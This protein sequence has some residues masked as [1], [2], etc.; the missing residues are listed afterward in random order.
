MPRDD[1]NG[2]SEHDER[3]LMPKWYQHEKHLA[4]M[5]PYVSLVDDRTVR[6][7]VNELFQCIRITGV[8]SYTT[9]DAYLDRV[10]ALF[11]R[12]VAQL[13][14]EFSFYLHKVSKGIKVDLEPIDGDSFAALVDAQ[15]RAK[16]ETSGL[17]DKTLT[18]TVIH[19]PP[20]KS[21]LSFM[22]SPS[23]ARLKNETSK[24]LRRLNEAVGI[25]TSGLANLKPSVLSAETGE[26]VGFLGALNTGQERP[27]YHTSQFGFLASST[28][29]TRVTFHGDYFE[30][31]E[32]VAG[33]RYGK[34]YS[35]KDYSEQTSCT[36][37]DTLNLPVDMIVTHS[38][39]PVNTNMT[40][41]RIKRQVRQMQAAD[42][43]AVSLR[44]NLSF[45]ADDLEAKRASMGDHHMV[46]TVFAETLDALETL[47]AE[48]VNAAASEGVTMVSDRFGANTHYLSQHPGNQPKRLR[49][50]TITNRNFADFAA[51]HRTQL[52]KQ[53]DE[54]PWGK[55]ISLFPTP[56]RSA[57]RFSFHEAGSPDKEPTS[58]HTL[59]MGRPGSGKSVLAAFLMTQAK[60]AGARVFIFDYRQGMEMAVRANGGRYTTIQGG[61]PTGL[62]PLWTEIDSRG[63]AWLADWFG[64]LLH[65]EDKPLTPAQTN[66]IMECVRQ[67]AQATDPGL[68][69]WQNFA[70]LF[71]SMDDEGDLNQRVL[72]W[73]AKGRFGWIFG[74]SLED[75]F[76]LDGDMV[77]FDLT[78]ILDSESDKERMA[79]L[80]Y[81]FR[82]IERKIED[83]RP[84]II[85]IDEAWK[86]LDNAYFAERLSQWLVT[87]RKQNT[88][89][90]MMTQYASQLER[91]RTGKTI[92][93][94][95]PTQVL[96]P[97]IRANA[98]DYQMLNLSQ[99]ELDTLLSTGTQSRLAL[100]RDD[101]G[102]IV[103]DADLS[104]LGPN[105]TILGGMEAGEKRVGAD[106]RDRPDFW[107]L[108]P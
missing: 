71:M 18:L 26:L 30:L 52:G 82:R 103:V 78:G 24:R 106:Y 77:G 55:V 65:R 70:S 105:L 68:R 35:I 81:L 8:N 17:R 32:G 63:I 75:T 59:I 22:R 101:Q 23:P 90:V 39:T 83:R 47:G 107:R 98:S 64:T 100:I 7:R 97:N 36:M 80:S 58:G 27:L 29:N 46:V 89:A 56:E 53:G 57:Y 16:M 66:R 1:V 62:N 48:I 88:V 5:L 37:F 94:A 99:K 33:R 31:S 102:S 25:F 51:F 61:M 15:W 91:T 40:I 44:E 38:F 43:A 108:H 42:D 21:F 96:L 84:T 19:R 60:R 67:N 104:A 92:I 6:T 34:S 3:T 93:E 10:R 79:V 20:S 13:G 9:D 87:A 2:R 95:V 49:P 41:A 12:I 54:V 86:A 76:S 85:L 69:N 45:L 72:E 4:H 50:S 74:H 11:A 73:A 14:E 28:A